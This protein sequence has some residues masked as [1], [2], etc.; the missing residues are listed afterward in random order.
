MTHPNNFNLKPMQKLSIAVWL[1]LIAVF[2][3]AISQEDLSENLVALEDQIILGEEEA[4]FGTEEL[5]EARKLVDRSIVNEEARMQPQTWYLRG[6]IYSRIYMSEQTIPG[7]TKEDALYKVKKAFEKIKEL[8][9]EDSTYY[10]LMELEYEDLWG[11]LLADG[12]SA[13]NADDTQNAIQNFESMSV[14]KPKDSTGYQYAADTALEAHKYQVALRN[15]Q[16]L[17]K[18]VPRRVNYEMI[19]TIQK[20]L[21]K[22]YQGAYQTIQEAKEKL[23]E[24]GDKILNMEIDLLLA[25]NRTEEALRL[26]EEAIYKEPKNGS[27]Y[28]RKGLVLEEL[29]KKEKLRTK[30]DDTKVKRWLKDALDAYAMTIKLEKTSMMVH[31]AYY[32]SGVIHSNE[33]TLLYNQADKLDPA[34]DNEKISELEK[35]GNALVLEAVSMMVKALELNP[36]SVNALVAL[37]MYYTN[38]EMS[39]KVTDVTAKLKELG[40]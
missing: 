4:P 21:L 13:S 38:L 8:A 3:P 15:F 6:T 14:L 17:V 27:L 9:T 24:V 16:E 39:E 10:A 18:I 35:N 36:Q 40:Y 5:N 7:I 37:R 33:A 1:L 19:I 22:D 23:G 26:L 11:L 25:T 2:H 31:D 20:D 12:I 29:V 30:P 34:N 28:L 32:N